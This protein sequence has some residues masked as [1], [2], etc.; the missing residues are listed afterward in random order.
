MGL[1]ELEGELRT[2]TGPVTIEIRLVEPTRDERHL[3]Q[4]VE[5]QLERQTWSGGVVAVRW[6]RSRLGRLEQAQGC[7]VWRRCRDENRHGRSTAWSIDSAAAWRPRRCCEWRSFPTHSPS[8]R[9]G[10]S[11]GRTRN[12][13]RQT[14]SRC[15]RNSLAAVPSDSWA[16]L[17][18]LMWSRSF[19]MVRPIRMVWQRQ[20]CRRGPLLGAGTDRD[21]LVARAGRRARLLPRRM[22][23]RHARLDLSRPAQRSLVSARLLRLIDHARTATLQTLCASAGAGPHSR[24]SHRRSVMSSFIARRTSPSWKERR[25]PTSWSPR[26]PGWAMPGWRSPIGTAWRA[27]SAP[28]S[29]PRRS[30]SSWSIGAEVTL[31]DASPVLLWAMNRDGYGRL[32]RL[33]TRG[34]RQA[35]KGECRL[36][37]ADVAE[38]ASGLLIG[39][40]LPQAGDLTVGFAPLARSLSRSNLRRGRAASR[41]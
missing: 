34:R 9:S 2:E 3:A 38:H 6:T 41:P 40:L 29:P 26:R 23:G 37:F 5:L 35:P 27:R 30:A 33:L 25:I 8:T 19:R 39:V 31:V 18:R 16:S 17:S 13:R 4:L 7:L 21:G 24:G 12:R 11:R 1:Q 32:C 20:D 14:S 22:G 36:A 15:P 10:S 28:T